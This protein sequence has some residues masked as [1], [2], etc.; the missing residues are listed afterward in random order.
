M[1]TIVFV[2]NVPG[3]NHALKVASD[4]HCTTGMSPAIISN[5]V[6][7]FKFNP[8]DAAL[9]SPEEYEKKNIIL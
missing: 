4:I 3:I 7:N 8:R 1:F 2:L 6:D 9:L 5:G